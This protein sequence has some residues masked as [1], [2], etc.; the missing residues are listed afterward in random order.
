MCGLL[1]G[2]LAACHRPRHTGPHSTLQVSLYCNALL[3]S[4]LSGDIPSAVTG[5]SGKAR[6]L[7]DW[8]S[9]VLL[10]IELYF[11][12]CDTAN[13]FILTMR[14]CASAVGLCYSVS[15]TSESSAETTGPNQL[16]FKTSIS[17]VAETVRRAVSV[18]TVR[19]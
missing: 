6:R 3:I 7:Q 12:V 2:D 5:E 19:T 13:F 16:C 8:S 11:V 10:N 1:H 9:Y 14:R 18:E 4:G 15:V 17:A